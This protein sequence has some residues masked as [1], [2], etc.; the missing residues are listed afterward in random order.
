MREYANAIQTCLAARAIWEPGARVVPGDYGQIVNGCFTRLGSVSELGAQ[1]RPCEVTDEGKHQFSRGLSAQE[2][3]SATTRVEWTGELLAS[4]DWAGG[5]GVFLGAPKSSLFTITDLGRV[6]RETLATKR[7]GFAWR[8]VRQVRTLTGGAI[9]LG[10]NSAAAG[11]LSF[12]QNIPTQEASV[13]AKTQ[14]ADGFLLAQRGVTGAVYAHTV[15]LRP[16]LAH[17][18]APLDHELWF[19]DDLDDE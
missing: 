16:W 13:S 8:L 15:R 5:A 11:R 12:E 19:D 17:G 18:S 10:G 3:V 9:V 4:L 6:V 1:L 2:G 14:R 7:W